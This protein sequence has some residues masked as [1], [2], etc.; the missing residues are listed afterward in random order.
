MRQFALTDLLTGGHVTESISEVC[1]ASSKAATVREYL[2]ELPEERRAVVAAVRKVIL[3]NLPEGY[4]ESMNWGMI[5][6][7]IPLKRYPHTYNGQPLSYA[8]L[9]AQKNY[10]AVYLMAWCRCVEKGANPETWMRDEFKKAG[11]KL[12]MG[13]ACVRFKK[14]EDLPLDVIGRV[15]A[16]ATPDQF[17]S[18]YEASRKGDATAKRR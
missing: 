13:R 4:Q 6:Y 12:D 1:M 7:E 11:K 10:Y 2:Q 8:G 14:L 9:G 5:S 15:I 16:N 17:I 18:W 3:K